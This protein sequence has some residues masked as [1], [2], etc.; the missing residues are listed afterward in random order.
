MARKAK[1]KGGRPKTTG[2]GTLIALRCHAP[3]LASVDA[4]RAKQPGNPTRPQAIRWLTELGLRKAV[5]ASV[6]RATSA[7]LAGRTIDRLTD[8]A[9]PAEDQA[10]RKRRLLKGP[11]EFRDMRGDGP[12][13]SKG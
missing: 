1:A 10:K 3:L 2:T 9:A 12:S 4:W 8:P 11:K 13:K 6:G 5:Q 7:D